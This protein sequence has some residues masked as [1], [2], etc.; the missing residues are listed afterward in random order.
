MRPA[1]QPQ[2]DPPPPTR[3]VLEGQ[4]S[5]PGQTCL[6]GM[7]ES[8]SWESPENVLGGKR[9]CGEEGGKEE[10]GILVRQKQ[11]ERRGA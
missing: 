6:A 5:V 3:A 7:C 1:L 8:G 4:E 9:W 2:P 10:E 11:R